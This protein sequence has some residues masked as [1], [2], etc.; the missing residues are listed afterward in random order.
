[1]ALGAGAEALRPMAVTVIGGMIVSTFFTLFVIPAVYS[2]M[3]R[4]GHKKARA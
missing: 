3:A 2:L 1:M 4:L